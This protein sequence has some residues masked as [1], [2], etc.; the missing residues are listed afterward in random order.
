VKAVALLSGG[1]DSGVAAACYAERPGAA[2]VAAVFCDYGQRAVARERAAAQALA[3][4]LGIELHDVALPWLG[5]LAQRAGSRLSH[6]TGALP[7][8]TAQAPGDEA[9]A[10]AVWV[11]ARNAVFV[12]IAAAYAETLGAHRVIAGFNAEEAQNFAD[13]SAAF[14]AAATGYLRLG[15]QTGVSVESPTIAWQKPRIVAEAQ[16]LGFTE[17]DFWSC[18]EGFEQPCGVCESCVRS[19]FSR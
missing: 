7:S 12:A 10:R 2:L 9:S 5:E 17:R 8:A 15:T 11:P 13:N 1:L 3:V 14:V 6:G 4:R 18:Y 16:R 19:R